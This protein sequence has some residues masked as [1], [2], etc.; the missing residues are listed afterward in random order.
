MGGG[1]EG[2][3]LAAGV[4]TVTG[5]GVRAEV[6]AGAGGWGVQFSDTGGGAQETFPLE[7]VTGPF[8][9]PGRGPGLDSA[10]T[11]DSCRHVCALG[12][13]YRCVPV[14]RACFSV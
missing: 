14:S 6:G 7:K 13:A 3:A 2:L 8:P 9:G 11:A 5:L 12:A 4:L 1:A 10:P